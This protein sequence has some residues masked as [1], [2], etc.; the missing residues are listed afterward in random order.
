MKSM[1]YV[2]GY[3][4]TLVILVSTKLMVGIDFNMALGGS[5]IKVK[6]VFSQSFDI[7]DNVTLFVTK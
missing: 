4:R 5:T 7:P 6:V 2:L 3:S 1:V